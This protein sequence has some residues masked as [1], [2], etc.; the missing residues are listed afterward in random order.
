MSAQAWGLSKKL[1][2]V[3][4]CM[5]AER[6]QTIYEVHPELSFWAM[7]GKAPMLHSK[8]TGGG[9]KERVAALVH[10]GGFPT[11]Y[12]E[13][14][15]AG[16]KVGRDDFLDACAA[17]WTATRIANREGNRFPLQ[18]ERDARGLDMAIWY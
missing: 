14:L 1:Q 18:T 17:L 4:A 11:E 13:R 3:D 9:T 10:Q 7:K 2:E 16:L 6:Q 5:T 12:V 8:K 15:P